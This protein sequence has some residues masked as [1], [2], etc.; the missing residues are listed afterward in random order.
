MTCEI[1]IRQAREEDAAQRAEL[2]QIG[3]LSHQW[4]AFIYFLFQELTLEAVLLVG[5]VLFIFCGASP[6]ACITLVPAAAA[7]VALAV[8]V[9]HHSLASSHKKNMQQE[10][11]GVVAEMRGPLG[12]EVP[13]D[14]VPVRTMLQQVSQPTQHVHAKLVGTVSVSE[15][16]GPGDALWLHSLSVH[17]QWRRRGAGRALLW[18]ARRLA[19]ASG[20]R[21]LEALT[22]ELQPEARALLHSLG[23]ELRGT[24]ERPLVGAALVLPLARLGLDLPYA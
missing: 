16:H 2:I 12:L 11:F 10:Q 18:A 3:L 15:F 23:W 20:Q 8:S 5:A 24:Y 22:S 1:I 14:C 19:A 7:I 9:T 17:P 13:K 21:A 6:V 4:N